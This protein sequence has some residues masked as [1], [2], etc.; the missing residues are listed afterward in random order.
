MELWYYRVSPLEEIT[1]S[2][3]DYKHSFLEIM[4]IIIDYLGYLQRCNTVSNSL[5]HYTPVLK[6]TDELRGPFNL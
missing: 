5:L 6:L 4:Q 1:I 3:F 2:Q